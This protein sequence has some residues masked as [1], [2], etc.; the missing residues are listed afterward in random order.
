MNTS[1]PIITEPMLRQKALPIEVVPYDPQW[2]VQFSE[3]AKQIEPLFGDNFVAI[4]HIGS[5]AVPGLCA[6]PTIDMILE[7]KDIQQVDQCNEAMQRLGYVAWGEYHIPGRRFFVKGEEKRT[8]HI[9]AFQTDSGE[10]ARHL[11]VRDYLRLHPKE[12]QAYAEL[13]VKLAQEFCHNRRGYVDA[14]TPFVKALEQR[15]IVFFTN[16]CK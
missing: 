6:K 7:V 16:G 1:K 10:I 11:H 4:H 15:A 8:H 3:E 13:K 2:P 12:A 9:H 14:K 5:T